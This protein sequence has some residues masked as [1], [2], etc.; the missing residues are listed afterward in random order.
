GRCCRLATR[1]VRDPKPSSC[2]F[3]F[4]F[5]QH[6]MC[7]VQIADRTLAV[8]I[9]NDNRKSETGGFAKLDVPRYDGVEGHLFEMGSYFLH[10]LIAQARA[11][12]IQGK[13]YP[14]DFQLRIKSCLDDLNGI[15][16]LTQP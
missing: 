3:R 6:L 12:I 7:Q 2:S 10:D 11:G 9:M 13:Q 14:F 8:R 16:Q 1:S 15:K 4:V 5:V